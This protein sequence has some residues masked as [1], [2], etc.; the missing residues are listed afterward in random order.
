MNKQDLIFIA[1]HN[2]MVG[3]AI[4]KKLKEKGFTNFIVKSRSELDL[5]NQQAVANFYAT[6]NPKYVFITAAKVGGIYANNTYRAEFIYDNLMI[7][8]NL[9]HYAYIHNVTKLLYLGSSCIYPKLAPQPIKETELLNGFLEPTNQAYA[10]AKIA[11]IELCQDYRF[12]Y[13]CNFIAAMPT[14]L[15]G[16]NDNYDLQNAHVLPSLLRKFIYAKNNNLPDVTIWGD[17]SSLREFLHVND[18]AE[19]CILLMQKYE[20]DE[21]INIGTGHDCS[22]FELAKLI[23]K[24]VGYNGKLVFDTSKPNGTPK[25]CLDVSKINTFGWKPSISLENGISELYNELKNAF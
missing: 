11:G 10:V 1:G 18:L 9:I 14:N 5:R 16:P 15:Y 6:F 7:A 24:I 23:Q 2:G 21:I 12:Q 17:G 8:S 13:K 25:K 20:S 4:L 22:I 3:S 19:A